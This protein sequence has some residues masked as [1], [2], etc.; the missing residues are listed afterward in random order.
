MGVFFRF[1]KE[2]N[3]LVARTASFS[4]ISNKEFEKK[5]KLIS[6]EKFMGKYNGKTRTQLEEELEGIKV[7]RDYKI[8][9]VGPVIQYLPGEEY[10][11]SGCHVGDRYFGGFYERYHVKEE[12]IEYGYKFYGENR[13]EEFIDQEYL[14]IPK[15]IEEGKWDELER[16]PYS[17]AHFFA[18]EKEISESEYFELLRIVDKLTQIRDAKNPLQ[19]RLP[20]EEKKTR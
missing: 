17:L 12:A 11:P 7:I 1:T 16:S 6:V 9:M 5:A 15:K 20:I 10:F 14:Q 8:S 19:R 4:K 2:G 3:V 13:M 18:G